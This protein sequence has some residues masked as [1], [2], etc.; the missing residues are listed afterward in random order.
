MSTALEN[1]ITD[2]RLRKAQTIATFLHDHWGMAAAELAP[3]MKAENWS[4][5]A[6]LCGRRVPSEATQQ[7]VIALLKA[8]QGE[9]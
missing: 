5:I 7:V 3:R 8:A 6:G 1:R 4:A 9:S 2:A